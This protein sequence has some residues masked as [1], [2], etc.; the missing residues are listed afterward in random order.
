VRGECALIYI[1]SGIQAVLISGLVLGLIFAY[2]FL[3]AVRRTYSAPGLI[4]GAGRYTMVLHSPMVQILL[5]VVFA[6]A[7]YIRVRSLM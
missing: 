1:R 5:L 2:E 6:V 3:R 7:F 4:A